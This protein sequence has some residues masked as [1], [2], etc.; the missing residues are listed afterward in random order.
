MA[1]PI[2]WPQWLLKPQTV[3][4]DLVHRN[5]RSPSAANGFT[6]VVSNSAGLWRVT[7]SDIPAY[8]QSMIKCWRAIDTL[9]EGQLNPI[10]IPTYDWPRSPASTDNHGKNVLSVLRSV[11]PYSTSEYFSDGSGFVSSYTNIVSASNGTI[12]GTTISV[13]K[14]TPYVTIEP[15]HRFSINDRLYQV[16]KITSQSDTMA[17]F[18]VRPP[19]REVFVSGDRL[20]FDN[21][22]LRVKLLDDAAMALPLSF[23]QRSFPTLDFI[24][25]L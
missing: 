8:D 2:I 7:F 19:F 25:D 11:V 12:G 9:A 18:T 20:E 22:R 6:Q 17:T 23:N 5:L 14:T 16:H 24:E 1:D 15:G 4:V 3:S 10:S 21:P 13:V